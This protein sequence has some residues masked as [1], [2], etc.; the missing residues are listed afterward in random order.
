MAAR[1]DGDSGAGRGRAGEDDICQCAAGVSRHDDVVGFEGD[2]F[3]RFGNE[4]N[5]SIESRPAAAQDVVQL[6]RGR[7]QLRIR[8]NRGRRGV[9]QQQHDLGEEAVTGGEIDDPAAPEKPARAARYFPRLIQFLARQAAR[10]AHSAGH[11]IEERA[12]RESPEIACGQPALRR[13]SKT[14]R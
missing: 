3:D 8:G 2:A 9:V 5:P 11:A 10:F 12:A 6:D 7:R 4:L 1:Q 14:H 13:V